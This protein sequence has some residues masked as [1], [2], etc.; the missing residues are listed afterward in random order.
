MIH[1][2]HYIS[3]FAAF[4]IDARATSFKFSREKKYKKDIRGA[5]GTGRGRTG[6]PAVRA[7]I[8]NHQARETRIGFGSN[9]YRKVGTVH[10]GAGLVIYACYTVIAATLY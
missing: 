3:Q 4:F 9:K 2:S 10:K 8:M 7:V 5:G 6:S 1:N